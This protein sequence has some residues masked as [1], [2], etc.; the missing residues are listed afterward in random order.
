MAANST[1]PLFV[2]SQVVSLPPVGILN[3]LCLVCIIFVCCLH[4]NMFTWN[5]HSINFS[6]NFFSLTLKWIFICLLFPSFKLLQT[7][8][9]LL[10]PLS[11]WGLQALKN[12]L[13]V[14][15]EFSYNSFWQIFIQDVLV[16]FLSWGS[17][18]KVFHLVVLQIC[19]AGYVQMYVVVYFLHSLKI[20]FQY[21]LTLA[22]FLSVFL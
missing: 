18:L 1:P 21:I 16:V 4:L 8:L 9:S 11:H 13:F 20:L 10:L 6:F 3:L 19:C 7:T 17:L 2:N 14:G 22:L 5:L 12:A 15:L